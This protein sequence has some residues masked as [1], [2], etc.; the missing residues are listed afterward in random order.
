MPNTVQHL[1]ALL[2]VAASADIPTLACALDRLADLA[3]SN[4]RGM[5]AEHLAH[6]AEPLRELAR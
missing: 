2:P 5:F 6:R 3:L 1:S 4:D